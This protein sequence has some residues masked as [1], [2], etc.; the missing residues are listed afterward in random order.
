MA[1]AQPPAPPRD[2]VTAEALFIDGKRLMQA[3]EYATACP[4]L[5][6]SERLD[7]SGGTIFALGLCYEGAGKLAT[8]WATFNEA[9]A[10]ARRD[11]RPDR[12]AGALEH[13]HALEGRLTRVRIDVPHPAPGLE[14]FR[15]GAPVGPALW[16]TPIPVDPGRY[17]FEA[18]APG[19]L[20]WKWSAVV[21]R[22]GDVFAFA[23]PDLANR[24]ATDGPAAVVV[25]TPTSQDVAPP[26]SPRHAKRSFLLPGI[27]FGVAGV[28]ALVGMG[29]ALKASSDWDTAQQDK[30]RARVNEAS[31]AGTEADV[32][33]GFFVTAGI[34]G[35]ASGVLLAVILTSDDSPKP[36]SRAMH[37]GPVQVAPLVGGG[38]YGLSLGGAL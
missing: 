22:P 23:V 35:A 24:S 2:L 3:R 21:D 26:S 30:T 29:F 16:G 31:S 10:M 19:K 32:A 12:E 34:L 11:Q 1:H 25:V 8:A 36:A 5:A 27:G 13:V 37:V 17:T 33:T 14:V 9:L 28:A 38:A 20:P 4:K 6:E 7:P 18:R 15:D